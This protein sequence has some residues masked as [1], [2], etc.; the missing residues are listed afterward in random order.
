VLFLLGT[1]PAPPRCKELKNSDV[2]RFETDII[3]YNRLETDKLISFLYSLE[4][5]YWKIPAVVSSHNM[6]VRA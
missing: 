1:P 5:N 6:K 4:I 2:I 3:D